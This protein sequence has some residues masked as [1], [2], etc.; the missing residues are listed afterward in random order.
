[1]QSPRSITYVKYDLSV[2][3][4]MRIIKISQQFY[5][6]VY[7]HYVYILYICIYVSYGPIILFVFDYFWVS[8]RGKNQISP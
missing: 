4:I 5:I 7:K 2:Y 8:G 6:K 1:M 3:R